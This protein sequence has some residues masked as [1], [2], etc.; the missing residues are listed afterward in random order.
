MGVTGLTDGISRITISV[1]GR[2]LGRIGGDRL[3]ATHAYPLGAC[4]MPYEWHVRGC[5]GGL[6]HADTFASRSSSSS[7]RRL[8]V[9]RF[10]GVPAFQRL[11]VEGETP[12]RRQSLPIRRPKARARRSISKTISCWSMTPIYARQFHA[13]SAMFLRSMARKCLHASQNPLLMGH[14]YGRA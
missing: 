4:P 14:Q 12:A 1:A 3:R 7:V 5:C 8:I 2:W 11:G 10:G 13:S 9:A 6:G